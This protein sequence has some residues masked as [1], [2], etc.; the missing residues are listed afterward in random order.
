MCRVSIETCIPVGFC[1]NPE[2]TNSSK[3][4]QDIDTGL[5]TGLDIRSNKASIPHPRETPKP[6]SLTGNA[7]LRP[8][9][10]SA[11]ENLLWTCQ[12]LQLLVL[13]LCLLLEPYQ[14]ADQLRKVSSLKFWSTACSHHAKHIDSMNRNPIAG[15]EGSKR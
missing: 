6:A 12:R 5:D 3:A 4:S 14:K 15:L 10:P 13:L 7:L 9:T 8:D 11:I 1:W 2:H